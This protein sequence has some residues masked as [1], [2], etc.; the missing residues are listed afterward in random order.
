MFHS[1]RLK[2]GLLSVV[3]S[4]LLLTGFGLFALS[5]LNRVGVERVDR[6]LRALA[7]A[8]IRQ[9]QP[10]GHWARFDAALTTMYG[11]DSTR[12]FLVKA[13]LPNGQALYVS[14]DWPALLPATAIPLSLASA[15]KHVPETPK[16]EP[17][18][19]P[20]VDDDKPPRLSKD[21]KPAPA[22]NDPARRNPPRRQLP[23]QGPVCATFGNAN[24]AWRVMTIANEEVTL[25]IAHNLSGLRA[26]TQR[27]LHALLVAVPLGLLL[28]VAGGWLIGHLA[29]RPVTLIARTAESV[30]AARLDARIPEGEA[31]TEFQHLIA[32]INSMLER[33]ERS[34][35]QATRFS[36]DAAHELKTPLAVLQAQIERTLQRSADDSEEQRNYAE[37]LEEL[38]RLKSILRKLLLL[39]QADAG[40]MPLSLERINLAERIRSA[41]N[42]VEM[43]APGRKIRMETP[44]ELFVQADDDLL[45]QI[46]GNL[47]SNAVKFGDPEGLIDIKLA[48]QDGQAVLTVSNTGVPIPQADHAKV[49]DR[50]YRAD[51]A[52]SRDIEG[53]GLGLSLAREMA[54]A[55]GGDLTLLRSDSSLT[56][57]ALRLPL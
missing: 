52:R 19:T 18:P 22:D 50:F 47:I 46:I 55:H 5:V 21:G 28:I 8:T 42:D 23:V 33:L 34:F 9:S 29:L 3:L 45:A 7:D 54:R 16:V 20:R 43:L 13:T 1:F 24:V 51:A 27:F 38:Q 57:F 40:E 2:I 39:S 10:P 35:R 26:E 53:S 12:Q 11:K 30:T 4:G 17:P 15:P 56:T 48:E 14:P 37:Q 31:D 44:A 36:A 6:E 25:S 41:E 32:L 49:F